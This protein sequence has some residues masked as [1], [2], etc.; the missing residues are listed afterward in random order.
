MEDEL[1]NTKIHTIRAAGMGW[2]E[3]DK[4]LAGYI[5]LKEKI[6]G[7]FDTE[8]V[9]VPFDKEKLMSTIYYS[10]MP[11]KSRTLRFLR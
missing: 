3:S 1:E 5:I 11:E 2:Q 4:D 10:D 9:Y 7:G 8:K 6:K